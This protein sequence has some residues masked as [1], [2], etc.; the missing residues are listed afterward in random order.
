MAI[1]VLTQGAVVAFTIIPVRFSE[2]VAFVAQAVV[3]ELIF[4]AFVALSITLIVVKS[5]S[6]FFAFT[7]NIVVGLA[8]NTFMTA[9]IIIM[10]LI[11]L[12]GAADLNSV[13]YDLIRI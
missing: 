2:F 3:L 13:F 12:T 10:L 11:G 7:S 1:V 4:R 5:S 6:A 9:A 8:F